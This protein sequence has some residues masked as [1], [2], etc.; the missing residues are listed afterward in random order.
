MNIIA[1][2]IKS[3]RTEKGLSQQELADE[4]GI[5]RSTLANYE[6][7]KR[8]PNFETL[9]NIADFFNVDMNYLTGFS[10]IYNLTELS[11]NT[12]IPSWFR[13]DLDEEDRIKKYLEFKEAEKED[14]MASSRYIPDHFESVT[15]AMEFILRVP[16]V[17]NNCGYD[18]DTMSEEEIIEMAEDLSEMLQIMAKKHRKK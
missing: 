1:K 14:S 13:E 4:L 2:R 17:A 5:G 18:L 6:Q 11:C 10:D 3:L 12:P 9:E 15:D 16:V 7:A 8:E